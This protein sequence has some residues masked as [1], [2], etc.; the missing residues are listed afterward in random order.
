MSDS[1][2]PSNETE[3]VSL[4]DD[5][6]V[7]KTVADVTCL[8]CHWLLFNPTTTFIVATALYILFVIIFA[9]FLLLSYVISSVGSFLLFVL[10]LC[11]AARTLSRTM[12]FAGSNLG[13]Q[14]SIAA[15]FLRRICEQLNQISYASSD[16][17]ST[18]LLSLNGREF[19]THTGQSMEQRY[20][21]LLKHSTMLSHLSSWLSTG[22]SLIVDGMLP[23]DKELF[24]V[25]LSSVEDL[26]EA[27]DTISKI[28]SSSNSRWLAHSLF[29]LA[30]HRIK[31]YGWL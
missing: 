5:F 31:L 20:E 29:A 9:P 30:L 26:G 4:F 12:A 11:L 25:F 21:Y 23:E 1:L 2:M 19:S 27:Q 6:I 3:Q 10:I 16:L 7:M 28:F 15:D 13:Y 18:M 17:M 22:K 8:V 14:R 24:I